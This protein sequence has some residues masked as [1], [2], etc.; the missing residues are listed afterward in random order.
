MLKVILF[1]K[2]ASIR[3]PKKFAEQH[4]AQCFSLG[5]KGRILIAK[6]GI[7]GSVSGTKEQI[8]KYEQI[9]KSNVNFRGIEFKE[10][11][12]L[13]HPF[14]RMNVKVRPELVRFGQKVDYKNSG[15]HLSPKEFITMSKEKDAIILDAR[16]NY[17]SRIGKFKNAITPNIKTFKEFPKVIKE[18]KDKKDKKILMYC[19]GGIRCEKASAFL[20]KKG[21]KRVY[22]LHGGILNFAKKC[23]DTI[24]EGTCFVFDKRMASPVN[25]QKEKPLS[26]CEI[27]SVPCDLYRNCRNDYCDKLVI[28]CLNCEREFGGCCSKQCHKLLIQRPLVV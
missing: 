15:M 18:L 23:P 28:I 17:E 25:K 13:M 5:I 7:N 22:Q 24:W 19:T 8:R 27:C 1:Y 3:D 10:E 6:E 12:C 14:K 16:N 9:L 20:K 2:Y 21:F 26:N 11:F 4:L